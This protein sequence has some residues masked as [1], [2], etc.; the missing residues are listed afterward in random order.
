MRASGCL[1]LIG[2]AMACREQPAAVMPPVIDY[3]LGDYFFNGP[4]TIPAGTVT[5]R[6][7]L[8]SEWRMCWTSSGWSRGSGSATSWRRAR[9]RTTR[10]G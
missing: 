4:D 8:A 10:R 1:V 6:L 7:K 3:T 2:C 9:A 5:I